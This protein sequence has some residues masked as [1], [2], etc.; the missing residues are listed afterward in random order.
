[1]PL[2][3]LLSHLT[4]PFLWGAIEMQAWWSVFCVSRHHVAPNV[5]SRCSYKA[6]PTEFISLRI[7]AFSNPLRMRASISV[8]RN[9]M[10]RHRSPSRRRCRCRRIR[11]AAA[12]GSGR[13]R[14]DSSFVILA[15]CL[16]A[17][18]WVFPVSIPARSN[19]TSDTFRVVR[20]L[21][22]VIPS[23]PSSSSGAHSLEA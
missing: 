11:S 12:D 22:A 1:V 7:S 21:V 20:V 23:S 4:A 5:W 8:S 16:F 14:S 19:R 3:H 6:L 2:G 17:L 18:I 9:W 10:I 13:T 15:L